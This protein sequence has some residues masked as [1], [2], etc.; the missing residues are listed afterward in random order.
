MRPAVSDDLAFGR[1]ASAS[2]QAPAAIV[3]RE[4]EQVVLREDLAAVLAGRG[5]FVLLSG[6]AGI[7]KTALAHDLAEQAERLGAAVAA[8]H[9]PESGGAPAF[10]PWRELLAALP[11]AAAGADRLPPPFGSAA[12]AQ[13][14][15]QLRQEVA[16]HLRD[17]AARQPLLLLLDDLHWADRDSL[18][19]LDAVTRSAARAPLLVVATYREE[20]LQ[21]GR[22]L[23]DLLPAL[24]RDRP[25]TALRLDTLA[26]G[27]VAAFVAARLG[28]CSSELAAYLHDRC[29]GLP[30]FLVELLGDLA[31]RQLLPHDDAG[32]LLPPAAPVDAPMA[33]RHLIAH[34][35][36]RLD[37]AAQTLLSVAAVVGD[38]WDLGAVEALLEWD[39][40]PLLRALED[41]LAAD[42]IAPVDAGE[43]YR[44]RHGM[45]REVLYAAQ[46][47][48]RRKRLHR[49]LATR[50][51]AAPDAATD[52]DAALAF[53]FAAA[54]SWEEAVRYGLAA[55][56]AARDRFAGHAALLAYQTAL[57]AL[58][59]AAEATI[60]ELGVALHERAAQAQ[61]MVGSL[62]EAAAAFARML[63]AAQTGGDR[64][65]EGRALVWLSYV[66][67]RLY[68]PGGSHAAGRAGLRVAE[69]L[70]E[71]R[72]LALAHWNLGH[73]HEIGGDLASA[74]DHAIEAERAAR[75]S[76][77]S[78][79]LSRSLQ[80]RA[81]LANWQGRYYE[82]ERVAAESLALARTGRDGIALVAAHWRL[83]IALGERGQYAAARRVLSTGLSH[84]E[85]LGEHYY[86]SKL[87]NTLGWL[88]H[89]LADH[90]SGRAWN[91]RALETVRGSHGDRVTEA[92][93]YALLDLA[94]HELA[95]GDLDAAAKH[96]GDVEPLLE[97]HEY[98][99]I[100][101]L[102]RYQL[103]SGELSLARDD[104]GAALAAAAAALELATAKGMRKNLAKAR[105]LEGRA[106]LRQ[107]N[108]RDAEAALAESVALADE[109]EHGSLRW[110][111]RLWLGAVLRARGQDPAPPYRAALAH[112]DALARALDDD[113]L[114]QTFLASKGVN[115]VR[116]ALAEAEQDG[117]APRPAGLT[118]R[119]LEV[120]RMLAQHQTDKE[121]AAALF[122]SPRTV[123]THVANIFIKLDV[124]NRREA[125]AAA[126]QL[127]LD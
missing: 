109:I 107:G 55:G 45:I 104:A 42:V 67:R 25:L 1:S 29:D 101:Y 71:Q 73:L 115:D 48:R 93:R 2:L 18:E 13:S 123:S 39:E 17:V 31:E 36:A 95:A 126:A 5:R 113:H 9:F 4:R 27:S 11:R 99:R 125:A 127:G 72:L 62:E 54:E 88:H 64:A 7:G 21:R 121:I 100:R 111:S 65:G 19:L 3:G 86:A 83:G 23:D 47:A 87:L 58:P 117:P 85:T 69:A 57:A 78:N 10:A 112:I 20:A 22:P 114:R 6:E 50:L 118:P 60:Q 40:E 37:D 63:E 98:G 66:R 94:S 106:L 103:V 92:E 49:R 30:L 52:R 33:L 79:L 82:A 43:R 34:R 80:V 102:N 68:Q 24:R 56:D 120:L 14:A 81:I 89:E 91:E 122:L 119:E 116:A 90:G 108:R 61:L 97:R 76:G 16:A 105:L 96:L 28:P 38:A 44:F 41:A 26:I 59:R 110:Q 77:E 70:A 8:A 35:I 74:A 32:R 53:H 15:Y 75:A 84:A 12:P 51:A 124:A 46:L